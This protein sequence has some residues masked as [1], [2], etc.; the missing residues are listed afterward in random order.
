MARKREP[1]TSVSRQVHRLKGRR[2]GALLKEEVHFQ[3]GRVVGY[4]LAYV[5]LNICAVDNGRV[6]GYDNSHG[7]HHRHRM[8]MVEPIEFTT[9]EA[10][11]EQFLEEVYELW[12]MEDEEN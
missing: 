10:L 8:G 9:Y 3:Q 12:R 7:F 1:E 4:A 5:N 11:L 6:L 2:K